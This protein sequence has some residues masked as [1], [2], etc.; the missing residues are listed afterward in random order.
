MLLLVRLHRSAL[1]SHDSSC[2]VSASL[3]ASTYSY[4]TILQN[5]VCAYATVLEAP[6]PSFIVPNMVVL[7]F[8]WRIIFQSAQERLGLFKSQ[9]PHRT[10]PQARRS[11]CS[12]QSATSPSVVNKIRDTSTALWISSPSTSIL[13]EGATVVGQPDGISDGFNIY[14]KI[15]GVNGARKPLIR[16]FT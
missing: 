11:R 8:S 2:F 15:V 14:P 4:R 5:Q 10:Y 3:V 16:F 13:I 9:V 12:C 6:S 7:L 1:G